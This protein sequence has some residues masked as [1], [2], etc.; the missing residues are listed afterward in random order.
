MAALS[1]IGD[2]PKRRED[3]RFMTGRGAY[4]D[5]LEFADLAFAVMLLLG[6]R[7]IAVRI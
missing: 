3:A 6:S 7:A 1:V 2:T 4:L 5:D